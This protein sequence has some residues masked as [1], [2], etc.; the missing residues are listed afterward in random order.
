MR[1]LESSQQKELGNVTKAQLVAESTQ[2]NLKDDIGGYL[3]K[4]AGGAGALIEGATTI[5]AARHRIT[6]VCGALQASGVG[7]A[8]VRAIHG[9]GMG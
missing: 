4:V 9:K 2:Q 1:E 5:P 7:K 8:A 3:D 6:Q